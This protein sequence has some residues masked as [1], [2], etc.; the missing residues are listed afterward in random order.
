MS[1][2][3]RRTPSEQDGDHRRDGRRTLIIVAVLFLGPVLV[4]AGIHFLS[5][6]WRPDGR[7]NHGELLSP[8]VQLAQPGADALLEGELGADDEAGLLRG[9]WWF[10]HMAPEG[11]HA[12]CAEALYRSRQIWLALGRRNAAVRR[13]L[14]TDALPPQPEEFRQAHPDLM[15]LDAAAVDQLTTTLL[16]AGGGAELLLVDPAGQLVLIYPEGYEGKGVIEDVK[17]LLKLTRI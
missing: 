7:T 15:V 14:V 2:H 3:D 1:D 8:V 11:C 13:L 5:D 10:V 16:D 12:G 4:A 6:G 17:K 9:T